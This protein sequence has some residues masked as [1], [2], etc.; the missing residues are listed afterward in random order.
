MT[1]LNTA[2][3]QKIFFFLGSSEWIFILFLSKTHRF[4]DSTCR[5]L[6][7]NASFLPHLITQI[8][9]LIFLGRAS[10]RLPALSFPSLFPDTKLPPSACWHSHGHLGHLLAPGRAGPRGG[11][12]PSERTR[13]ALTGASPPQPFS[14]GLWVS[15]SGASRPTGRRRKLGLLM[16]KGGKLLLK[17]NPL[18]PCCCWWIPF[19]RAVFLG[20][21]PPEPL[22]VHLS[23]F[24]LQASR[25]QVCPTLKSWKSLLQ[26]RS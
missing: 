15:C 4:I 7:S 18:P 14:A 20:L 22:C 12:G 5:S 23:I 13:Q 3:L 16:E 2:L 19:P 25:S 21:F 1:K 6:K 10:L 9:P 24:W 11:A 8:L 26:H 17:P